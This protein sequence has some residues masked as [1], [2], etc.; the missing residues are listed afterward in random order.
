MEKFSFTRQC[1]AME[2]RT[3]RTNPLFLLGVWV[4]LVSSGCVSN[5]PAAAPPVV[6]SAPAEQER[7]PTGPQPCDVATERAVGAAIGAQIDAL[8]AG[9]FATAYL[10]AAPQ[11]RAEISEDTFEAIIRDGFDALLQASSFTLSQC[12]VNPSQSLAET[13]VTLRTT[14]AEVTTLRYLTIE[15]PEGWRILAAEPVAPVTLGT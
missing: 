13:T 9:D 12:Q 11:F 8:R 4:A 14:S 7:G 5:Q 15:L 6:E 2:N 1:G 3:T 10:L